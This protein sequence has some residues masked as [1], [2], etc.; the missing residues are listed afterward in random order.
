MVKPQSPALELRIARPTIRPS[1][2]T[3]ISRGNSYH[4]SKATIPAGKSF[5][6]T[7]ITFRWGSI[8]QIGSG[9][10][11]RYRSIGLLQNARIDHCH[12]DNLNWGYVIQLGDWIYGVED[13]NLIECVGAGLSHRIEHDA[14]GG[15]GGGKDHGPIFLTSARKNFGL[16]KTNTIKGSGYRGDQWHN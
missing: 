6:L 16:S 13:H 8:N 12:F 10:A 1:S 4:Y 5:R 9:G 7:G 2:L 14:W 15:E 3:R 11:I